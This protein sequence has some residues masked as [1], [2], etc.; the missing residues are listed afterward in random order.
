M[1]SENI[2]QLGLEEVLSLSLSF[3]KILSFDALHP[4]LPLREASPQKKAEPYENFSQKKRG[5]N[6]PDFI[7]LIQ[8]C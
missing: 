7:S 4:P 2:A 8:K 3:Q 1:L 6:Q 5:G